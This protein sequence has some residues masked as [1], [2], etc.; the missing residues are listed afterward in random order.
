L[1]TERPHS[2]Q[3]LPDPVK[4]P[5]SGFS[6]AQALPVAGFSTEVLVID[7]EEV[8]QRKQRE[9]TLAGAAQTP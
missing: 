5:A 4:K 7:R 8:H 3:G 1:L 2:L 6:T 9:P